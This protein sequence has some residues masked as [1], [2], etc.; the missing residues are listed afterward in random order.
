MLDA[1]PDRKRYQMAIAPARSRTLAFFGE[2]QAGAAHY[3]N[4][5][6]NLHKAKAPEHCPTFV[7]EHRREQRPDTSVKPVHSPLT[8]N[9]RR[10]PVTSMILAVLTASNAE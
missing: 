10:I 4:Y 1:D 6:A 8:N 9:R 7:A 3:R 5:V 2:L